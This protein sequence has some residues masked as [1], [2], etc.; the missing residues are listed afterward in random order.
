MHPLKEDYNYFQKQL[1]HILGMIDFFDLSKGRSIIIN[2]GIVEV[3]S[4][5]DYLEE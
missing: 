5:E 3:Q 4:V 1:N 2:G